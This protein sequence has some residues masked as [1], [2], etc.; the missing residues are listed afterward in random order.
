MKKRVTIIG[1][2]LAGAE[3][4]YQIAK[5]GMA[6]DLYEMRPQVMTEAHGGDSLAEMVCSNSLGSEE[7]S[8]ASGLL[9]RELK[10]LDSFF[11]RSAEK[12]RVPA[13]NSLAVDRLQLA[14]RHYR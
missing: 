6:V 13:G 12:S 4:A 3:A 9:K 10:M 7:I 5:S 1:G 2:G 14:A 8:S 11:L